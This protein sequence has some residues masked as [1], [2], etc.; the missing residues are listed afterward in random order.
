MSQ[1]QALALQDIEPP[2][3]PATADS[4]AGALLAALLLLLLLAAALYRARS[5]RQCSLRQIRHLRRD[6]RNGTAPQATAFA[7]A[8][9]LQ[10]ALGLSPLRPHSPPPACDDAQGWQA[11]VESL[12]KARFLPQP[13]AATEVE[14]LLDQAQEILRKAR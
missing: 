4:H 9:T 10:K 1:P 11:F 3:P 5:P 6:L 7:L 12:N 2:T 14:N 8:A 13:P